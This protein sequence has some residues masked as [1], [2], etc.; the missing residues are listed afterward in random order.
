VIYG[1]QGPVYHT[2]RFLKEEYVIKWI[3]CYLG[4]VFVLFGIASLI[5]GGDLPAE[6]QV[7]FF[8][9]ILFLIAGSA[10]IYFG[11]KH[12]PSV[13]GFAFSDDDDTDT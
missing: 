8:N 6:L 13:L 2:V 11:R 4:L 1:P 7:G 3:S 5:W 12:M 10:L 9:S